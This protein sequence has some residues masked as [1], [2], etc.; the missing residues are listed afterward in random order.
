MKR[1]RLTCETLDLKRCSQ[2]LQLAALGL[3]RRVL[4]NL[5]LGRA[6]QARISRYHVWVKRVRLTCESFGLETMPTTASASAPN[7]NTDLIYSVPCSLD[8]NRYQSKRDP[9]PDQVI[10]AGDPFQR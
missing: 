1:V 4:R 8:L 5:M 2:L 7:A 3:L 9:R 10:P 6:A